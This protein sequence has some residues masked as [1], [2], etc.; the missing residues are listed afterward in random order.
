MWLADIEKYVWFFMHGFRILRPFLIHLSGLRTIVVSFGIC[1]HVIRLSEPFCF[2]YASLYILYFLFFLALLHWLRP[3]KQ[4]SFDISCN[5][6]L[7]VVN[8]LSFYVFKNNVFL[9][10]SWNRCFSWQRI[11]VWKLFFSFSTWKLSFHCLLPHGASG[12][13]LAIIVTDVPLFLICL[14]PPPCMDDFRN[15]FYL[16]F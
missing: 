14:C 15:F 1:K 2:S 6:Y 7:L 4:K 5:E 16:G 9:T 12:E 11:G 13:K 10:L 8:S 3:P